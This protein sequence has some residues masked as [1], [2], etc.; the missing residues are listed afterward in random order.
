M[1]N[2][3]KVPICLVIIGVIILFSVTGC[4]TEKIVTIPVIEVYDV[5]SQTDSTATFTTNFDNSKNLGFSEY[6]VCWSTGENPTVNDKKTIMIIY[7]SYGE[8]FKI[9]GL[10]PYTRY[11]V[12]AYAINSAGIG[13]SDTVSITTYGKVLDIEGND[14]LTQKFGTQEW[15]IE[16]MQIK[17]YNNNDIIPVVPGSNELTDLTYGA[18]YE[19]DYFNPDTIPD[20]PPQYNWYTVVDPRKVCP[21]GWHIPTKEEWT[22][23]ENF[24]GENVILDKDFLDPSG[25]YH[26]NVW[27]VG[28]FSYCPWWT[29]SEFDDKD[30][31]ILDLDPQQRFR[32]RT[33]R[34]GYG[35]SFRC[36]KN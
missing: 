36:V 26:N 7:D 21:E 12:R 31:W 16:N 28:G 15:M 8:V 22:T 3:C 34:K 23:L 24:I 32:L 2:K 6:G 20:F 18:Y 19:N 35:N 30:A 10:S 17:H 5:H 29:A 14:Y 1:R 9:S 25:L 13:Y 27:Y 33:T 11:F 4:E